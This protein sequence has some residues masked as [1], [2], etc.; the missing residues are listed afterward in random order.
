MMRVALGFEY[1]GTDF[2]GW[3]AQRSGRTVQSTLQQA[4][5]FVAD[6]PVGLTV[7]GRTDA[8]VHAANQVVHFDTAAERS[9][10]EW[11]L[12]I[13]AQLPPDVAVRWARVVSERFDARRSAL[14]RR[15][16]YQ[17]LERP[18]RPALARRYAWWSRIELDCGAMSA[19]ASYWL[20][21]QDFA[22][23]R[24]AGCQSRSPMRRLMRV[25]ISRSGALVRIE[26]TA[27]AFLQH[28]VRNFVGVL[29]PIGQGKAPQTWARD[30]LLGRDRRA[31]GVAAPPWGLCL[32]DVSYPADFGLPESGGELPCGPGLG[33]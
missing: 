24:A 26:F 29:I 32:M 18:T 23:F 27:N 10:R 25:A 4:V 6:A 19:A 21:E 13:N 12:G 11:V 30:V 7:A 16:C 9:E 31:G 14:A 15:Y 8:G 2:V 5:E 17:I 3:Q 20:G 28:M 22:S 33:A 1:D